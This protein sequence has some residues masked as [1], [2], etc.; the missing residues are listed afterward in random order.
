MDATMVSMGT[1]QIA[2][3]AAS[4]WIL[5]SLVGL[6]GVADRLG[7]VDVSAVRRAH[8]DVIMMG[9]LVTA[10]GAVE[11]VPRWARTATIIGAW[12]NPAL[13]LPLAFNPAAPRSKAY[14][15]AS[16]ASFTVTCA[17]WFGVARAARRMARGRTR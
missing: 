7:V 17:G 3:G 1:T 9:G 4:G 14:Q 8:V 2:V 13:F 11:G 5:A 15:A 16:V 12:T 10:A 6:P